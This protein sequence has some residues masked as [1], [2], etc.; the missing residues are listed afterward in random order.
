MLVR[1]LGVPGGYSFIYEQLKGEPIQPGTYTV[2][3][4][5]FEGDYL[6]D[7]TQ[8]TV[9]PEPASLIIWGLLASGCAGVAVVRRRRRGATNWPWSEE[10]R[11]G[12]YQIVD[13]GRLKK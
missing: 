8:F 13:R 7:S 11:Q 6:A 3:F 4:T 1:S 5:G 2:V 9:T 12:I 10:N